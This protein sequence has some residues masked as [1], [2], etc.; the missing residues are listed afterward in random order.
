MESPRATPPSGSGTATVGRPQFLHVETR[1]QVLHHN[2]QDNLIQEQH[3]CTVW[4]HQLAPVVVQRRACIAGRRTATAA[5]HSFLHVQTRTPFQRQNRHVIRVQEL[6]LWDLHGLHCLDRNKGH[7]HNLVQE[8]H[9]EN[10]SGLFALWV[11]ASVSRSALSQ[12]GRPLA[13]IDNGRSMCIRD[14]GCG[15]HVL[16]NGNGLYLLHNNR[17][18][19]PDG[20]RDEHRYVRILRAEA[21]LISITSAISRRAHPLDHPAPCPVF[22][23]RSGPPAVSRASARRSR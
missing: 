10:F 6:Q 1:E 4:I 22:V 15:R 8:P 19:L 17:R 21:A 16:H 12:L 3:V 11:P 13:P 7:G 18:K 14:R 9:L 20:C 2:G 23:N 5:P